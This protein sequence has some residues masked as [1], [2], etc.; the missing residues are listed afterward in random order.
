[1]RTKFIFLLAIISFLTGWLLIQGCSARKIER[2][3]DT[4]AIEKTGKKESDFVRTPVVDGQFY[5][6][7]PETL[8]SDIKKYLDAAPEMEIPGR[9]LGL[10][11]PHAGY[12]YSAP[13]A[14]YGYKQLMGKSYKTV[15]VLAP[16]HRHPF[17]GLSI[18]PEG[19]YRTPL[20]DVPIDSELAQKIAQHDPASIRFVPAAHKAEHSLE[21]QVPFLQETL[22][23][24]WKIVPIIFG[25]NNLQT[26]KTLAS[27]IAPHYDPSTQLIIASSDMS[28]YYNYDT[29]CKM[30]KPA[31]EKVE[32]LDLSGF[33]EMLES[34]KAEFCGIGPVITL[35]MLTKTL[36]GEA[37]TLKYANSGDTAGSKGQVVGYG[38][39][40]FY[41]QQAAKIPAGE[42]GKFQEEFIVTDAEKKML[43]E[44]ARKTL[45]E[46]LVN[47]K[48]I[49]F[50]QESELLDK[51]LGLFVTLR[52]R[53]MLR[54]CIGHCFAYKKLRD[55]LPELAISAAL[56]DPRFPPVSASELKNIEIEISLLSP[57]RLVRDYNQIKIPGHGVYVKKEF[58][59]GV[60]LPQ[61]ADETGWDRETFMSHLCSEKAGLPPD[62]WKKPGIDLYVFTVILFEEKDF[63]KTKGEEGKEEKEEKK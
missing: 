24:G 34:G 53:G 26:C 48:E 22:E 6:G 30:D 21:V 42:E 31:L 13:V 11:E 49:T 39:V 7:D 25:S 58:R 3:S 14:A 51:K 60:F 12:V 40:A 4:L 38:C 32:K 62:A 52:K 23:P 36:G 5:P 44:M 43:L 29:A 35:M 2:R 15:I 20:G 46:A 8:K 59:S 1:M 19:K 10:V 41:E 33:V 54:G 16:S 17:S 45:T 37:K 9:L 56:N 28:H 27:A 63:V 55:A 61:V 18:I 57:M 50:D 47:N